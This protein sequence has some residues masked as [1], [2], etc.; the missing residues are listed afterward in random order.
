MPFCNRPL[1]SCATCLAAVLLAATTVA[2]RVATVVAK[3]CDGVGTAPDPDSPLAAAAATAFTDSAAYWDEIQPSR[4]LDATWGLIR[5]TNS[6]LEQN[7]PWKA[8]PGPDVDRVMGDALEVLRL[9]AILASP[10]VPAMP[11][12]AMPP[13]V[14]PEAPPAPLGFPSIFDSL[15]Y[16]DLEVIGDEFHAM[17]ST[18]GSG[19]LDAVLAGTSNKRQKT[20]L[21]AC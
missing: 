9:V 10:A 13:P 7:E 14:L 8:E 1:S 20:S 11:P 18:D 17:L 5:A 6:H 4:A 3:K 21:S 2:A 12:P 16:E 19:A 15:A